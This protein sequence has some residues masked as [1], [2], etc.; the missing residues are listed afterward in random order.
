MLLKVMSDSLL[1]GAVGDQVFVNCAGGFASRTHGED[2]GRAAGYNVAA[3]EDASFG[4]AR[5]FGIGD[6]VIPLVSFQVGR[7]A[8]DER[9]GRGA[10]A[11]DDDAHGQYVFGAG[12]RDRL[13]A[14][15]RIGLA[16]FHAD[17][18]RAGEPASFIADEFDGIGEHAELDALS[19]GVVHFFNAGRHFSF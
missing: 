2:H 1:P 19:F 10:N 16:E 6:D 11:D 8:L 3:C 4:S 9:I 13:A 7:G 5:G 12:D 15:I 17:A 14:A 18:A